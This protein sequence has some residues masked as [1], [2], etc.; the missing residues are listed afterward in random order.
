MLVW[1][2]RMRA[3]TNTAL[4]RVGISILVILL[5]IFWLAWNEIPPIVHTIKSKNWP[6]ANGVVTS[7]SIEHK[8]GKYPCN[9]PM[10]T[11]S[12]G[13]GQSTYVGYLLNFGQK[14][15]DISE[16]E[17]FKLKYA[18]GTQVRVSYD[19]NNP[20]IAVLES[21]A[22]HSIRW[23]AV[24]FS[25]FLVVFGVFHIWWELTWRSRP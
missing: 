15:F 16:Q 8:S 11:Y 12:Y 19:P 20:L 14:C 7:A 1:R 10:I 5:A 24:T 21:Y 17:Q 2:C 3:N 4:E 23:W 6:V 18:T 25:L 9:Y 22:L 13:V